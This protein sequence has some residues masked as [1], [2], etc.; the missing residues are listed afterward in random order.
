MGRYLFWIEFKWHIG[1]GIS[2]EESAIILSIP[3]ISI[4]YCLENDANGIHF[5]N[6]YIKT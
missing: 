2:Y 1:F 4:G 3:F 6:K 5:F